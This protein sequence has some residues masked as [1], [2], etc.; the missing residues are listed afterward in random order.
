MTP[1]ERGGRDARPLPRSLS[2]SRSSGEPRC[3]WSHRLSGLVLPTEYD[4]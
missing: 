2:R 3:P 1:P 4:C